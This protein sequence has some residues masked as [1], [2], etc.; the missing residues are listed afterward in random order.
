MFTGTADR[1]EA[2][3]FRQMVPIATPEFTGANLPEGAVPVKQVKPLDRSA[4]ESMLR[5]V[6]EKWN[7]PGMSETLAQ[8]FYDTSRLLDAMDTIVPRDATL[9]LQSI[10]GIQTLQQYLMPGGDGGG[11]EIV[12]IVSVTARTQVEFDKPGAGFVRLPGVNEYVLK[13]TEAAP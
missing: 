13:I 6:L 9:K 5:G 7:A 3:Q 12:S 8:E 1:L 2:R 11:D 4:V 10:Q